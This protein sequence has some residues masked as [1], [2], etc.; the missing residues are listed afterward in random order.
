MPDTPQKAFTD[1][2]GPWRMNWRFENLNGTRGRHT[3][4]AGPKFAI[5]ITN[6]VLWRL[7]VGSSFSQLLGDPGIG[8]R[9]CHA[10]VDHL[11]RLQFD[12][13]ERKE[14]SK[15]EISDLE[16]VARPDLGG[17][18]AQKGRPRLSSWLV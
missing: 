17:V 9:A 18:S 3:S 11:S 4:E 13:E 15:E 6:Q 12:E 14:W 7:P 8:R 2:I 16:E 10:D 1:R 5:V